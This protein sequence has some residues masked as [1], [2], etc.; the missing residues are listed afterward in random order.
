MLLNIL[1][2]VAPTRKNYPILNFSS[3]AVG[4]PRSTG[5]PYVSLFNFAIYLLQKVVVYPIKFSTSWILLITSLQYL[6][7][8]SSL[9]CILVVRARQDWSDSG[10]SSQEFFFN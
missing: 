5:F 4:K 7:I 10:F 2:Q 6:S 1:H 9:S 3:A 8:C